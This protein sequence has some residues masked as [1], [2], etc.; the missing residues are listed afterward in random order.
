MTDRL[1]KLM[2]LHE[3]D[4]QDADAPYMIA[5]EHAKGGAHEASLEW[6]DRC[7]AL[8]AS[9]HYAYFHK[10]RSLEALERLDEARDMLTAG[11]TRATEARDAKA[12]GE[13]QAYLDQLSS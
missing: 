13:L 11:V 4:P 12:L 6:Y 1:Q 7:L 3:V 2:T 9:Y 8:D 10:A 5:Q